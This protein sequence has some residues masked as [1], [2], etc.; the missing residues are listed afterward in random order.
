MAIN[1]KSTVWPHSLTDSSAILD[2][3][4]DNALR[5]TKMDRDLRARDLQIS[6]AA[7]AANMGFWFRDFER[8]D[9]WAC[10]QWRA[11]F[12]FSSSEDLNIDKFFG[13]LHP[14]DREETRQALE[15]AYQGDGRYQTEHRVILPD[16][17]VRWF[18]CQGRLELN[19]DDRPLRLQGI[20][21]D[22]TWRKVAE[23]ESL[24]HR[25]E[26]AHLLRVASL[27]A[28]SSA[29]AHELK[30]PLTA[31]LS[32]A[33]AAQ[34]LLARENCDISEVCGILKDVVADDKRAVEIIDRLHA[35]IKKREFQT[36]PLEANQ[37]IQDVLQLM[38]HE[39]TSQSVQVVT[40]LA[41]GVLSIRGDRVQ[42]QQVLI[43]LILNAADSM[44]QQAEDARTL[45]LRSCQV[46]DVVQLS[47]AD[48]GRGIAPGKE[49]I[50]FDSY[51]TTKPE[52]LG[53]GLSLSRSILIAHGGHLRVE[54]R[55][56]N[57][58]TFHCTIPECREG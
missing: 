5:A 44:S 37:L 21:L 8:D 43:N 29:L 34:L 14:N 31:I 39:L 55:G 13:R 40:D 56:S 46:G 18:A 36:Q 28:L 9:F 20:S 57:G 3:R 27:G 30:Q 35:L 52:G 10:E 15:K 4:S 24:A 47:V 49:E 2:A 22:V 12:G 42:L 51:Y 17:Q 48:S 54:N 41:P 32:N 26:A 25:N 7:E 33:Q 11:L 6:L 50:I 19:E 23:L 38:N 58:A 45:T 16:G 53:L 1:P